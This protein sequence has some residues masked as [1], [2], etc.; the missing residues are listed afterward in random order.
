MTHGT[1]SHGA[2][3]RRRRVLTGTLSIAL[4]VLLSIVAAG[5]ASGGTAA[6]SPSAFKLGAFTPEAAGTIEAFKSA[7]GRLAQSDPSLLDRTDSTLVN[8]MVKYDYDSVATYAGGL[9]GLDATSPKVTGKELKAN[10]AA[11]AAYG[12][13][14]DGVSGDI[15]AAV[16]SKV[17]AASIR[18]SFETAYGGVAMTL[19]A[20]KIGQL[21]QV[22]GVVAVQKDALNQPL[23]DATPAFVGAT[24]VWGGL[25]GSTKAGEGVIVGVLDT[26]IWPEHP[27][28][29]DNGIDHPGG[30]YGCEF[31]NGSA[32]FGPAFTCNDKLIGAYAFTDTY[33]ANIGAVPGEYCDNATDVCSARDANGHGT[34][35]S[36]TAAGSAVSNVNLLGVNRGSISGIAPGS[37]VIMYRVCLAQGCFGSDSVAA[38]EQAILDGVDVLNFSISGGNSA[39]TDPVELAFLEA[40]DAGILVNASAGN[41]GPGAGTANHAGPWTNTVGASTSN[42]HFLATLNLTASNGD[43][44]SQQGVTITAGVTN[45]DVVLAT[46]VGSSALCDSPAN[47]SAAG[48]VVV[49]QRGGNARVDKGFRMSL[50]GAAGMILFNP[51]KQ[52]LQSDNHWL[53]AIHLEG[54]LS[55]THPLL[56]FLSSH[57]GVKAN[58]VSGVASPVQGDVMA[59]FSSRGPLGDFIKPDVT[60]PGIQI[61]AG[62]TPTPISTDA[63]PP[64]QLYQAIAGTSMSSP[65]VAG[66]S[67]LVKDAHP[68]WS[69]GQIKSALM[70]SSVQSVVKENGTTAADPFD[71]GA[72]S[73]RVDR[74]IATR[75]TLDVSA[76]DYVASAGDPLNR[77]N[78][79]LPS[80]NAPTMS[81]QIS[82]ERTLRNV[83]GGTV[84]FEVSTTAPAGASIEVSPST[85]EILAGG[86]RTLKIKISG[87]GLAN[88]QYFGQITLADDPNGRGGIESGPNLVL[89]V[90]FNKQQGIV[91]LTHSCAP[92]TFPTNTLTSCV[93]R[94]S[95]FA[96]QPAS[97][98]LRVDPSPG[99]RLSNIG[100]TAGV[101][102]N[103]NGARWSGTLS[104]SLP[105]QITSITAGGGPGGG[106]LPLSLFG[107][108]PI[109]GVGDDTAMNFNVPAFT[110]GGETYNRLGVVSNGYV[111]V[112]GTNGA[113]DIVFDPVDL[114]NAARPNNVLAPYWTDLNPPAG[115]ALRIGTLTDGADT[116]IVIDWEAVRV[117]GSTNVQSF[118]I[119]IGVNGDAHPA[120]DNTFAYGPNTGTGSPEGLTRG[121]ENRD[122]TSGKMIVPPPA[123][124]T[125]NNSTF[126]INTAPPAAGGTAEITYK[127]SAQFGGVYTSL[128][129]LTSNLTPGV[130]QVPVTLTVT[131]PGPGR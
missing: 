40:Y 21:L 71:R 85:V 81:G 67:A 93:A 74:A 61:L 11:V 117:F 19:P 8:V 78:L 130:T 26:G 62:H 73:A 15:N 115:G 36:S 97:I 46:A 129:S 103:A 39:Y 69:P 31:G 96:A 20:N 123:N 111:V 4:V 14:L 76:A 86:T 5:A 53:P 82:T 89:P 100:G 80:I 33:M 126:R 84:K 120:E 55:G 50:A 42:R 44:F 110:Y 54:P 131:G 25:G 101:T 9:A 27:S 121:A 70:T 56:T 79:N 72:G 2:A 13:Y 58:W 47:A 22:D 65:H 75:V 37:H 16:A 77:I 30:T 64:G 127:A 92:T 51:V 105:P 57:T 66:M 91:S 108:P 99:L 102:G 34:H 94:A 116:W 106:Y 128:A 38:V 3:V 10:P 95:N 43:T 6:S 98:V 68:S 45:K 48:K 35:T 28:F 63:G 18:E 113:A 52:D 90:A 114:P 112:G 12:R 87:A 124:P 1:R 41:T 49:C 60:A 23:T 29:N 83:S 109:A 7:T 122:G 59:A 125:P 24:A 17:P 107:I 32:P 104:P 88:G 118:Q 119:W